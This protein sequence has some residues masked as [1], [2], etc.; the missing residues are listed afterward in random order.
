MILI[1]YDGSADAKAAIERGAELL[2]GQPATVVTVWQPSFQVLAYAPSG[3]GVPPAVPDF[4]EMDRVGRQN[5]EEQAQEGAE[6][7]R[8]AG[9]DAQARSCSEITTIP[10]AIL[11]AADAVGAGAILMG[12]R[13]L[14][15][16]KSVL[17]GS[18]T[19]GVIRHA[20]R[21]VIVVPSPG[22]AASRVRGR[23]AVHES[24]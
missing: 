5:A 6:L 7:A 10:E 2:A 8:A 9:F 21:V 19:H 12:S 18:V 20:D 15:G 4:Q 17:L 22:V 13:G 1:C 3:F 24:S 11:D 16:L 23:E 14:T